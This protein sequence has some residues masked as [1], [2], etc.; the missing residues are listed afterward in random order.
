MRARV[1]SPPHTLRARAQEELEEEEI[2]ALHDRAI[3][4]L[5]DRFQKIVENRK[6]LQQ[7]AAEVMASR[8]G[9]ALRR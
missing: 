9:A 3:K 4:E 6:R 7:R 2:A 5:R 1:R 8:K